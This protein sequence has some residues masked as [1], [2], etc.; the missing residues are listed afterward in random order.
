MAIFTVH[1][2]EGIVH[3]ILK[4]DC[5]GRHKP[6]DMRRVIDAEKIR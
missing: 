6:P 4:G 3:S 5:V 2:G 1:L